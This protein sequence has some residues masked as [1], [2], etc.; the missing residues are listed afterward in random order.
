[1]RGKVETSINESWVVV[2]VLHWGEVPEGS[3]VSAAAANGKAAVLM[4]ARK[5]ASRKV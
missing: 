4:R 3:H 1:M 2:Q 5:N